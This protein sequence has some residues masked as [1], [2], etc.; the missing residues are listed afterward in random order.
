MES[1]VKRAMAALLDGTEEL[2]I[3]YLILINAQLKRMIQPPRLCSI[4]K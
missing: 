1:E 3:S 4:K 2:L